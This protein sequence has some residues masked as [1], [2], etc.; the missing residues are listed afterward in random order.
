MLLFLIY[1]FPYTLNDIQQ[2]CY[3]KLHLSQQEDDE[4]PEV[5]LVCHIEL[6]HVCAIHFRSYEYVVPEA[7][8]EH[9]RI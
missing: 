3:I 4:S 2:Q 8:V 1:Y 9:V 5:A 7:L 6:D